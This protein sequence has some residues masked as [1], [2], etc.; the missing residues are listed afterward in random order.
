ML[1]R[2]FKQTPTLEERLD[3]EATNLSE[4]AKLRPP[5]RLREL[6]VHHSDFDVLI[7]SHSRMGKFSGGR[8]I[9]MLRGTPG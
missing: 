7:S 1:H 4:Q 6:V 2:R 8:R 5:G 3:Q 9:S